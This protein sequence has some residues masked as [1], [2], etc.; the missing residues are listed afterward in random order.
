[1]KMIA[2]LFP[3]IARLSLCAMLGWPLFTNAQNAPDQPA[4]ALGRPTPA[5]EAASLA[6]YRAFYEDP[7]VVS[8]LTEVNVTNGVA[9]LSGSVQDKTARA[10]AEGIA[11]RTP[12]VTRVINNLAVVIPKPAHPDDQIYNNIRHAIATDPQVNRYHILVGVISGRVFLAGPVD[13]VFARAK[14]AN[15]A[16][17]VPGVSSVENGLTVPERSSLYDSY[18]NT[19]PRGKQPSDEQV[20]KD[21]E[22]QMAASPLVEPNNVDLKVKHG[23]ATLTGTVNSEHERD[24]L[25]HDAYMGGAK[26]V[27]DNMQVVQKPAETT[28]LAPTGRINE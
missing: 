8:A 21:I 10:V 9:T 24:A 17:A 16:A 27:R 26:E 6:I 7:R 19:Y 13:T 1:M 15:L 25:I 4:P 23:V 20:K 11:S 18:G 2:W 12:G 3:H 28:A 22:S 5:D 14:I